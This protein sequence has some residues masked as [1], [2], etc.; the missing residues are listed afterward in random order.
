[1]D[2]IFNFNT[3]IGSLCISTV[4]LV[5][6]LPVFSITTLLGTTTALFIYGMIGIPKDRK[7]EF[8]DL[9]NN[10]WFWGIFIFCFFIAYCAWGKFLL[11][12]ISS[13][14]TNLNK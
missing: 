9:E 11:S 3:L 2:Y 13:I 7:L 12:I 14:Y 8:R 5:Y 1:M 10:K 4:S 6:F